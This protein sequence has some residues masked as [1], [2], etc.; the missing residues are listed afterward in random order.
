MTLIK[1]AAPNRRFRPVE[2]MRSIAAVSALMT[3]RV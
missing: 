2:L 1:P 3:R